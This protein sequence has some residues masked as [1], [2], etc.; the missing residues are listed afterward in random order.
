MMNKKSKEASIKFIFVTIL[1]DVIGF[2]IIIP[3]M[4]RL[5]LH[6]L[7]AG[8]SISEAAQYGAWLIFS[9]AITQFIFSPIIGNLSDRFGRRPVL[10]ASLFSF[11]LDYLLLA[12]A[13]NLYWLFL[14]R[15]IAGISG[16]SIT[17]ATAYIA[18]I[19]T[20]KNRTKNFGMLGAAF[21]IGFIIGPVIGGILG[22]FGVK[23]PF[24]FAAFLT[25]V[26]A[27][28][29][30]FILP[31]SL[32]KRHRRRFKW[33]NA[34]P[35]GAFKQVATYPS[36]KILVISYFILYVASHAI[37]SNW[38]FFN[39][40]KFN[41][42]PDTIG[43]SLGI[44]GLLVGLVQG[45]LVRYINPRLGNEKSIYIGILLYA[46]GMLLFSIA[47]KSWMMF[48]FLVPYCL[49]G[50]CGPALQSSI[51]SKIP[52]NEQGA[53]QGLLTSII[54][55]TTIIGPL[56]MTNTF[57]F[58]TKDKNNNYFPGAPFLLGFILLIFNAGI[59]YY[60]FHFKKQTT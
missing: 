50:I 25:L 8:S 3:V 20:E 59:V 21:G 52:P 60:D 54:S 1:I 29:G 9:Y 51:S 31:E 43:L 33:K 47:N 46:L 11:C 4:P 48:L 56:I 42:T 14:G 30:Y 26:N 40:E 32:N 57:A 38:S 37:H 2:G 44:V 13:P 53:I 17:T 10:L 7:P 22:K 12:F 41:W 15:I 5:I 49:G 35:I 55:V 34:N 39:I 24:I 23:M 36:I 6:Y 58:F 45:V 18:D 28:Y 19:S 27:G 16:A